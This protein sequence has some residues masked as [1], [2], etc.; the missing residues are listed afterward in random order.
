MY[1]YIYISVTSRVYC[2]SDFWTTK[3]VRC[4][5]ALDNLDKMATL[6]QYAGIQFTSIVLDECD[7]AR[8]IIET[9]D[10]QP[11]WTNIQHYYMDKN[12]K[13]HA[14]TTLGMKQVPFYVVLNEN[15]EIVQKGSKKQVNFDDIPG[16]IHPVE[17]EKTEEKDEVDSLCH[18][19]ERV[20]CLDEDF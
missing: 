1:I 6:P 10:K 11:R 7:G 16:M 8:N 20:F 17:E 2:I 12:F 9:P 19:V 15:G 4:P 14:K 5:D 13:E 3:C 18:E